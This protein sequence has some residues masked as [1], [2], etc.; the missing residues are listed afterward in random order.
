MYCWGYAK[1]SRVFSG[2]I[3]KNGIVKSNVD[4]D[5][6]NITCGAHHSFFISDKGNLYGW[7]KNSEKQVLNSS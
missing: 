6:I 3:I 2:K 5:L 7:G 1:D 4:Y